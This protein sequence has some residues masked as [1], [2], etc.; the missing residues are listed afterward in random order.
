MGFLDNV[1]SAINR[2]AAAAGRTADSVKLKAQLSDVVTKRQNLAAQLGASLYEQTKDDEAF[3]TGREEF[4]DGIAECDEQ[5]AA[6]Q[7]QIADVDQ[8]SKDAKMSMCPACGSKVPASYSVCPTCGA[9]LDGTKQIAEPD[10][11]EVPTD[12]APQE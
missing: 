5:R 2:G 9:R 1:S 3:R 8:A 6:L 12:D 4:Y 11:V 10:S 7:Q